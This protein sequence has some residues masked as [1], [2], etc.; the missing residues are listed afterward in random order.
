MAKLEPT[1]YYQDDLRG[2]YRNTITHVLLNTTKHGLAIVKPAYKQ[3][4]MT[5]TSSGPNC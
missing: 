2:H 5:M 4:E 1:R 3:K